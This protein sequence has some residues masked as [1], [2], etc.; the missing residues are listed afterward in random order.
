MCTCGW[1]QRWWDGSSWQAPCGPW[2]LHRRWRCG[3]AVSPRGAPSAGSWPARWRCWPVGPDSSVPPRPPSSRRAPT[4]WL[5]GPG[6]WEPWP[7]RWP[8]CPPPQRDEGSAPHP[9]R[10]ARAHRQACGDP[11]PSLCP[12]WTVHDVVSHLVDDAS[13]TWTDFAAGL[14][15][16]R[17]DVDVLDQTIIALRYQLTT[18]VGVAG[19]RDRAHGLAIR[20]TDSDLAREQGGTLARRQGPTGAGDATRHAPVARLDHLDVGTGDVVDSRRG[21]LLASET[22]GR[23]G[24]A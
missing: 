3:A 14:L 12:G 2:Q 5:A 18:S 19:G 13:T 4:W 16:A 10:R 22:S 21:G 15:R 11:T 6:R 8:H 7:P 1:W 20:A 23:S 24:A 17:F 9:R